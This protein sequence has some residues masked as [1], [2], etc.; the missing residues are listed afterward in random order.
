MY[1]GRLHGDTVV[2]AFTSLP[3]FFGFDTDFLCGTLLFS[4]ETCTLAV[5]VEVIWLL[6]ICML[7]LSPSDSSDR[8]QPSRN[9]GL[10]KPEDLFFL[11]NC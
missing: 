3:E 2:G 8:L 5:G 9:P 6:V 7:H 4:L 10:D 1:V 11:L